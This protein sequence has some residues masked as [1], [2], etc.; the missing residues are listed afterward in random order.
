ME[1]CLYRRD[2]GAIAEFDSGLKAYDKAIIYTSLKP[3]EKILKRE[4]GIYDGI[5]I[6]SNRAMEDTE[7]IRIILKRLDS[8][9]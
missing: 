2:L 1:L 9:N 7:S 4:E 3:F 6:Y 5:H 8:K